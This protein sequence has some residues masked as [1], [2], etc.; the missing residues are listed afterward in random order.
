M[1]KKFL[2]DLLVDAGIY[3]LEVIHPDQEG[4]VSEGTIVKD[5]YNYRLNDKGL[6]DEEIRTSL[7][8]KQTIYIRTIKNIAIYFLVFSIIGVLLLFIAILTL[9]L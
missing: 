6:T 2:I 8:A 9:P 7:L 3:D 4:N 1:K 5:G